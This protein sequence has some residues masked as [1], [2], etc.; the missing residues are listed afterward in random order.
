M[1]FP[2]WKTKAENQEV[3]ALELLDRADSFDHD[4]AISPRL[5]VVLVMAIVHALLFIGHAIREH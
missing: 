1:A 4:G 5:V 3:R 2:E